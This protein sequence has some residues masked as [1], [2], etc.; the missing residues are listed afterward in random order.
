MLQS[1]DPAGQEE[2][3]RSAEAL[4][5]FNLNG[6]SGN[7][8]LIEKE[9]LAAPC[10]RIAIGLRRQQAGDG[11]DAVSAFE[12]P[13]GA[14]GCLRPANGQPYSSGDWRLRI[15]CVRDNFERGDA[16]VNA[17][18]GG[19]RLAALFLAQALLEFAA[20]RTGIGDNPFNSA[21][22]AV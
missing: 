14:G 18:R 3:A 13:W 4:N 7:N 10:A 22:K 21:Q 12:G 16:Q 2:P 15:R 6:R 11:A 20:H 19:G 9:V 5:V 17:L 1:P 8:A